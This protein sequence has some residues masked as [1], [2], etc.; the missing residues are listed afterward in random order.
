[1]VLTQLQKDLIFGTLLGDGN[2]QTQTNGNSWRYRA[3]H[4]TAHESYLFH[5]YEILKD[6][7]TT[8]PA[9]YNFPDSRT[10]KIYSRYCFQTTVSDEFLFYGK[11]FYKKQSDNS[12]KK[13]VPK[14]VSTFLTP[15]ALAYWYMDDGALKWKGRSNAVRICTDSFSTDEICLLKET[16]ET[17]FNLQVSLQK[18]DNIQRLCILEQSYE[19]LKDLV[20]P[21]LIPSMYYKFPDGNK[22]VYQGQDILND[23]INRLDYP[24]DENPDF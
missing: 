20:S 19:M 12:W 18:K 1:M 23:I 17:K 7:C 21:Y 6:F 8:P 24:N 16:L 11:L 10:G 9:L 2:L 14:N 5:K 3:V 22:G 4:K 13:Q 15:Q